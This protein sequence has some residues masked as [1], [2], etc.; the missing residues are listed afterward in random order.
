MAKNIKIA[1][2][3]LSAN[4]M[5]MGKAISDLQ[6]AGADLIHVD[7]MDGSFVPNLNFGIKMVS[8]LRKGTTGVLDV[9]L[10]I[11]NPEKYIEQFAK[12]G[13]DY[14]TIHYEATKEDLKTLL[15]KIRSFG[16]KSG[17]SIKPDTDV[18]VLKELLP[19]CDMILIMSVYPGFGGQK[20]I[21]ESLERISQVK[22]YID[23][24]GLD[25]DLEVDGGITIENVGEVK[26]AGAN[27]I[28]AGST[29][30]NAPDMKEAIT[31]L[32]TL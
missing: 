10:M 5:Q 20:F 24:S 32:K 16:V 8:D 26:R 9:H 25:I 30:F 27:V 22:K 11:V 19:Y 17:L 31:A 1:P 4:Y 3:I 15:E 18:S 21:P 28:V 14:I 23:E 2:S 7:V 6:E 29:V 12:A 13:S